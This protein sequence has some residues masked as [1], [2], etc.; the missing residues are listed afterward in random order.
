[1]WLIRQ[2]LRAAAVSEGGVQRPQPMR[3][4]I[5]VHILPHSLVGLG[6]CAVTDLLAEAANQQYLFHL[7]LHPAI[8]WMRGIGVL[9]NSGPFRA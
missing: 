6:P 5:N 8:R 2:T 7:W 3:N 1:M 4:R 9:G